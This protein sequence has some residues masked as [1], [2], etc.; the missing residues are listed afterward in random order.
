MSA[1]NTSQSVMVNLIKGV[2][3][4]FQEKSDFVLTLAWIRLFCRPQLVSLELF[5]QA[6][7]LLL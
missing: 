2:D 1:F 4:L 3:P 6:P 7:L 5:T